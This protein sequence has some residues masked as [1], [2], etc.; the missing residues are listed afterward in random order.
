MPHSP[1]TNRLATNATPHSAI[2]G[3]SGSDRAR[4]TSFVTINV[5][6]RARMPNFARA[7]P[8]FCVWHGVTSMALGRGLEKITHD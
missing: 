6:G 3:A 7:C 5:P 1:H 2:A 8:K 4:R